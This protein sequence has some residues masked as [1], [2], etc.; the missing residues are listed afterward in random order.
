VTGQLQSQFGRERSS[1]FGTEIARNGVQIG[2][3][4]GASVTAA[5]DGTVAYAD[6]F[7]G[8]GQLIIL[9]HGGKTYSLYGHLATMTVVRGDKVT[10]GQAVGTVGR[11][12]TGEPALYFELRIDG[13]PVDPVIWLKR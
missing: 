13:R 12:P 11:T 8:F 10:R 3:E 4:D 5:R 9:D 1:R 7:A 6:V 2:A